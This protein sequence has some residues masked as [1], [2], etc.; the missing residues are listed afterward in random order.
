[1][2]CGVSVHDHITGQYDFAPES[3]IMHASVVLSLLW[4][5]LYASDDKYSRT[6]DKNAVCSSSIFSMING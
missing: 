3:A 5:L 6:L 2:G 1:M 4:F